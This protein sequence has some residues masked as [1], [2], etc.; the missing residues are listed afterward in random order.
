MKNKT[1]A[2]LLLK[3]IDKSD[4]MIDHILEITKELYSAKS[5]QFNHLFSDELMRTA[6]EFENHNNKE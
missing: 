4:Q 6:P 5:K 2:E 1:R 3:M